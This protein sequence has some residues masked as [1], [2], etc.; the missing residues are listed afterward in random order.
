MDL[1]AK[2]ENPKFR[3][4]VAGLIILPIAVIIYN[5][6]SSSKEFVPLE[7][8]IAERKAEDRLDDKGRVTG[9]F[10]SE[11]LNDLDKNEFL[12]VYDGAVDSLRKRES[13]LYT[14]K[15]QMQSILE[16]QQQALDELALEMK[17][18]RRQ[19]EVESKARMAGGRNQG[20]RGEQSA[21]GDNTR[22]A[23]NA[24]GQ[25]QISAP[26]QYD[27][28]VF[29]RTPAQFV[30]AKPQIEGRVIRTITQ[31]SVR[32]IKND[33]VIEEISQ[34]DLLVTQRGQ[35]PIPK[36]S[37][38]KGSSEGGLVDANE[39]VVYL[40]AGSFFSGVLLTGL[41]APTQLAAKSSPMPV[42]IRVKKEAILPNHFTLD[43]RE[44][45]VVGQAVG[46][47]S[48]E[49]AHIRAQTITCVRND[50][51]SV[52]T[53]IQANA[54]SDFDGKL[55][56]A[57]TLVSKNGNLLAGSMAAGF[58][59]GISEAVSPRRSQSINTSPGSQ[60]LWQSVDVGAVTSAGVFQGSANAMDRLA[61]YYI[62]L[63]EQIHPVIEI[64]P[65]RSVT[66]AVLSGTRLKL[67]D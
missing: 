9:L 53:A 26:A 56:I 66:F 13:K 65:G 8:R 60:D 48:S 51:K 58:M 50:G 41:D 28:R 15:A 22:V 35:E 11:G 62:A 33:G 21:R 47:L 36:T 37:S 19:N 5:S 17:D 49:R 52:E 14:E 2:W 54:V 4:V 43:I 29:D 23:T 18:I 12:N 46:D 24:Q 6:M 59:S 44:C 63:A 20:A 55:G 64:S 7:Q 39:G 10:D 1:K 25:S 30:T 16:Q 38:S 45:H 3:Q 61:E 27:E 40:P 31:R 57:G 34:E 32:S 42:I 67:G